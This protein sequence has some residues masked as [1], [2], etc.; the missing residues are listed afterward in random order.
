MADAN[1]PYPPPHFKKVLLAIVFFAF[2]IVSAQGLPKHCIDEIL[3]IPGGDRG[4]DTQEFLEE[5]SS[6]VVKVKAQVKTSGIPII[7]L[8]L[9]PGSD[10]EIT[11][12]GVSVGCIKLFPESPAQIASTIKDIGI[13]LAKSLAKKTA[14]GAAKSAL[15]T[16]ALNRDVPTGRAAS[17]TA[18][19]LKKCD[20]IFNPQKK[21]C[22]DGAAY[23]KCDGMEFN[24]ATHICSGDI[25]Y[26]ALCNNIQYNPTIQGCENDVIKAKCG[27]DVYYNPATH[28]CYKESRIIVKCGT[29]P[30]AYDPDLYECKPNINANG[31]F[32]KTPVQHG[33]EYYEAVLLGEQVWLTRNLNN[34]SG[35]VCYNNDANNCNAYGR[36]F[37]FET[38][39]TAC[40]VGWYLPSDAEWTML[41]VYAG[42]AS[43]AAAKKLKAKSFGGTDE[44][45][46][47]A[48]PGGFGISGGPFGS[49]GDYGYWW[50]S[51]EADAEGVYTRQIG[52]GITVNKGRSAKSNLFS[53]RCLQYADAAKRKNRFFLSIGSEPAGAAL[54]FNGV[55][56]NKCSVTPCRVELKEGK[57]N[58]NFDLNNYGSIDTV[59]VVTGERY[60]NI[61]LAPAFG[62]LK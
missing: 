51:T 3:D 20:F 14:K 17:P 53:V 1:K 60:I 7:G 30:Q 8:F 43:V 61:K 52:R 57:Y 35:G 45:G 22:Y 41:T 5:L 2:Q 4:F 48:L 38:A 26:R 23:D 10:D 27:M 44:Y 46:F 12:I 31:I 25:A 59:I 11:D 21:F 42:W 33:G 58:I 50:S 47:T 29:N 32:L 13:E 16:D 62:T 55:S 6:T 39:G 9:G 37:D 19:V 56:S 18:P 49:V 54:T 28:S 36:L 24:P 40:P 15:G 34:A